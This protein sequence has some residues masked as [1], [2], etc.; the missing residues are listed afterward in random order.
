MKTKQK[1]MV[2]GNKS[3]EQ[4]LIK[5]DVEPKRKVKDHFTVPAS[6]GYLPTAMPINHTI[7]P[8]PINNRNTPVIHQ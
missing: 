3:I 5:K 7:V 2:L 4:F 1:R 6:S 8:F